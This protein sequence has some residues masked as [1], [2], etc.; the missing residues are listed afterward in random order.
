MYH[1]KWH[2]PSDSLCTFFLTV[3]VELQHQ[4]SYLLHLINLHHRRP[5]KQDQM[6]KGKK[7]T[8]WGKEWEKEMALII[9]HERE[10]TEWKSVCSKIME[11]KGKAVKVLAICQLS[12][13]L[14]GLTGKLTA[15]ED[16]SSSHTWFKEHMKVKWINKQQNS[17]LNCQSVIKKK[18]KFTLRVKKASE[19]C[20]ATVQISEN[21]LKSH[22]GSCDLVYGVTGFF[23]LMFKVS[24]GPLM[25]K[26]M[27]STGL[28]QQCYVYTNT[29]LYV[30]LSITFSQVTITSTDKLKILK[31]SNYGLVPTVNFNTYK[32]T[33]LL[34]MT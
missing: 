10:L 16:N 13:M 8:R 30:F 33:N 28:V 9:W 1:L 21:I 31:I 20:H 5:A 27:N 4:M 26:P 14:P 2:H 34:L 19:L 18:K 29:L 3:Y 17:M 15:R 23:P 25:I 24:F 7:A 6:S 22:R 32:C 11:R 12:V